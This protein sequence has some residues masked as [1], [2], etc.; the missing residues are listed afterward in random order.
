MLGVAKDVPLIYGNLIE[1]KMK[2]GRV[3]NLSLPTLSIAPFI[4][5]ESPGAGQPHSDGWEAMVAAIGENAPQA[6]PPSPVMSIQHWE[7]E[8]SPRYA[9][10]KK[11]RPSPEDESF[12]EETIREILIEDDRER[13]LQ[14]FGSKQPF[15]V[16]WAFK[17]INLV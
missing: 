6:G 9:S 16:E 3:V 15:T 11:G 17:A 2:S 1:L 7:I 4:S 8:I 13:M 10:L 5:R 12:L 14:V